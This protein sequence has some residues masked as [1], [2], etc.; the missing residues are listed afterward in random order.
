MGSLGQGRLHE[1]GVSGSCGTSLGINIPNNDTVLMANV[2]EGGSLGTKTTFSHITRRAPSP[3]EQANRA[4]I[5]RTLILGSRA[6]LTVVM[7]SNPLGRSPKLFAVD[8]GMGRWPSA[9]GKNNLCG[10]YRNTAIQRRK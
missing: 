2:T 8:P 7:K 9:T 3:L 1:D 4:E 5:P 10:L 6:P